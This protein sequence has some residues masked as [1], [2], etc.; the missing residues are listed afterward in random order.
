MTLSDSPLQK[1]GILHGYLLG[2]IQLTGSI[3]RQILLRPYYYLNV[4]INSS[5]LIAGTT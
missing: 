4:P 1:E 2:T 3:K 5:K